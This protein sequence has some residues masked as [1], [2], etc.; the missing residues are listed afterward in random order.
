MTRINAGV[1]PSTLCD[2]HLIAEYRELPRIHPLALRYVNKPVTLASRQPDEFKLGKG[3]ML[4]FVDKGR[5]LHGRWYTITR[6]MRRRGFT[7]NLEW[8]EWP[9][10]LYGDWVPSERETKIAQDRIDERLTEMSEDGNPPR[11]TKRR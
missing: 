7:V 2:Q 11:Y 5:Y 3:H 9:Q 8:R 1:P 4:F 10:S 6:E